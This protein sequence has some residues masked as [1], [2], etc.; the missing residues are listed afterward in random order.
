MILYLGVTAFALLL[1]YYC[2]NARRVQFYMDSTQ[3][4]RPIPRSGGIRTRGQALNLWI[5]LGI[6]FVLTA[7]S[8]CRIAV[9]NDYWEY[10]AMFSLIAQRRVVSS[11]FGFNLLV[12]FVQYLVGTEGYFYLPIFG[13]ISV[14][15]MYFFLRGIFD[16][17][18]WFLGTMFLFLTNGYYFSSFNSVRY[19]LALAIAVY[20]I[21]Y[22]L[23]GEYGK[24]LLWILFAATFHK[25]VLLVIPVYLAARWLAVHRF[26]K[27]YVI[28]GVALAASL[29]FGRDIYRWIMFRFYPY[30]EDSMYDVARY[31]VTNIGKC[32]G[33]LVLCLLCYKQS[34]QGSLRNRFYCYLNLGGLILYTCGAFIPEVS[35]IGYY[36]VFPQIFLIPNLLL[37]MRPGIWKRVFISGTAILFVL[38]FALFLRSA[39][40][41]DIRLLPYLNWIFN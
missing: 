7:V 11:E 17:G 23:W 37:H 4:R 36:L 18:E 35:R 29:L 34:V 12:R 21:K 20:C 27:W 24:F 16:Q 31:S 41:T 28:L 13:A 26:N 19:Y 1:A 30:Y 9:G 25:S 3:G 6:Y 38:Y 32:A 8:A 22:V 15:T 2:N 33:T 14:V 5:G 10:T 40:Q 39:Y